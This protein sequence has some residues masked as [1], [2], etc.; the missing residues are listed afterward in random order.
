MASWTSTGFT[1]PNEGA[2]E[3]SVLKESKK[4]MVLMKVSV[5]SY[6]VRHV[7]F[8]P[9][10]PW[11]L[12]YAK[13]KDFRG[14]RV[15][16]IKN[17]NMT[18]L[19]KP[20]D[21]NLVQ[22]CHRNFKVQFA[23]TS[24]TWTIYFQT[25]EEYEYW[26]TLFNAVRSEINQANA[27]PKRLSHT[28]QENWWESKYGESQRT[29]S[30]VS[31]ISPTD[32]DS[33]RASS[34]GLTSPG[35][36][37][38]QPVMI[39][40]E[41]PLNMG[42]IR[43]SL[44]MLNDQVV[45]VRRFKERLFEALHLV[46]HNANNVNTSEERVEEAAA[47]ENDSKYARKICRQCLGNIRPIL[48][49][50]MYQQ[51]QLIEQGPDYYAFQLGSV[52]DTRD[53]R[54]QDAELNISNEKFTRGGGLYRKHQHSQDDDRILKSFEFVSSSS[55][56]PQ[57]N[58]IEQ[59]LDFVE[60]EDIALSTLIERACP[61][62]PITDP[63]TLTQVIH[64]VI[65][66][67]QEIPSPRFLIE[68]TRYTREFD[69]ISNY[70]SYVAEVRHA[71]LKWEI[72][73]R[74]REF[75][76]LDTSLREM[77]STIP[78]F[79]VEAR[80]DVFSR[81]KPEEEE[82]RFM[83]EM[84]LYLKGALWERKWKT[85]PTE[86]LR[87]AGVVSVGKN[88]LIQNSETD[89][90]K[91]IHL[92]ALSEVAEFGDILLFRSVSPIA[93]LQRKVTGNCKFDH[94]GMVVKRTR[95]GYELLEATGEGVTSYPLEERLEAYSEGFCDLIALR[96]V[97]F[98]R[99]KA[100][101]HALAEFT[102]Q[103]EGK[104]YNLSITK[105]AM[106]RM[107]SVDGMKESERKRDYFCSELLAEAFRLMGVFKKEGRPDSFFLPHYFEESGAAEVFLAEDCSFDEVIYVDCRKPEVK[108]SKTT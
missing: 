14:V 28:L 1:N 95:A 94:I 55:S 96:K 26:T 23:T 82:T 83:R 87:F 92:D 9:H 76:D 86:L 39:I 24:K 29:I 56:E 75:K 53:Y 80:R 10:D 77:D 66:K 78:K 106:S 2:N 101:S 107:Q 51:E 102:N 47:S 43:L 16:P 6:E 41:L 44:E 65:R 84:N 22:G 30:S 33:R 35:L 60:D 79:P 52:F 103:V 104:P 54:R 100:I 27:M 8:N 72:R 25:K 34:R 31:S 74:Y 46:F 15:L 17:S 45:T 108:F 50:Q 93:G 70:S 4:A 48:S 67:S 21:K 58:S 85:Q 63:Q 59:G 57:S 36:T 11:Y 90:R 68:L 12:R 98:P 71:G 61:N 105:I 88:E 32:R 3:A 64:L 38:R 13:E 5:Q 62:R 73:R 18:C 19:E 69:A 91:V 97:R 99:S 37:R 7:W 20:Q 42:F 40:V 89:G 49:R 81:S